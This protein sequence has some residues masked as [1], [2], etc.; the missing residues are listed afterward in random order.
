MP[1]PP[2][3]IYTCL[4][5][6]DANFTT[7][8]SG[9]TKIEQGIVEGLSIYPNPTNSLITI[10]TENPDHYLFEITSLNGQQIIIGEMEGTLHQI[11]LST[12]QKG[13]Y[14]ITVSSRYFVYTEKIIKL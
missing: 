3:G 8:C 11:D 5:N 1:F 2:D 9:S 6:P 4:F 13:V 7:E 12:V 14:L 10:E